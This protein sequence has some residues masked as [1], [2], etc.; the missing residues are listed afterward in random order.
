MSLTFLNQSL[1][2][3]LLTACI[4]GAVLLYNGFTNSTSFSEGTVLVCVNNTYGTV[5]DDRW[6]QLDASVVCAQLGFHRN[7]VLST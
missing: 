1:S 3:S 4:D 5:C 2:L 6:D 7:G